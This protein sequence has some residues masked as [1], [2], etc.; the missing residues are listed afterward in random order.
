M[1]RAAGF[2]CDPWKK[3]QMKIPTRMVLY[4]LVGCL[5]FWQAP[6]LG[7]S[8]DHDNNL[9]ACRNGWVSCDH[10]AFTEAE[11][12][13]VADNMHQRNVAD[14]RMGMSS[15]DTSRL[16]AAEAISL[17]VAEHQRNA[18]ACIDG[19]GECAYSALSTQEVLAV[20]TAEQQ[21]NCFTVQGRMA[22]L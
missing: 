9:L 22:I 10:A 15:C 6:L 16:T 7:Q 20:A 13:E 11:S 14:C 17:A 19:I 8:S 12:R 18:S 2:N 1:N 4:F 5:S 21:R 3:E